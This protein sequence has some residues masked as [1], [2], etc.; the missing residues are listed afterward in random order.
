V[1]SH[2]KASTAGS[3]QRQA[4][5]L[6]RFSRGAD[7][8]FAGPLDAKGSS[9]PAARRLILPAGV[10]V[11]LLALM[12]VAL[13]ASAS[14]VHLF[15]ETFGSVA[16]PSFG[17]AQGIAVDQSTGDVLVMDAGGMP[18]IKRYNADGTPADFSALGTN[19]ID[20]QGTGDET[21]QN[22]LGFPS[23]NESQIAVDNSG[24]AT[25]GN[26]YVTQGSPNVINIFS[27]AGAYLGQLTAAGATDF[28]EA[29]GVAVDPSGAV[30]VGDYGSGIQKF[31]PAANPPVNADNTATFSSITNPCTL[32][33][34]AGPTAGFLFAAQYTGPISKIDS[35]TGELKYAVSA[36]S[37]TT[38]SV[39]SGSGHVFGATGSSVEEFDAVGAGGATSVGSAQLTSSVRG[40]A[41]DGGSGDIYAS[42]SG[43]AAVEVFDG[44]ATV[45][46]DVTTNAAT[47]TSGTEATLNGTVNPDGAA[48]TACEF[49]WGATTSYGEIAACVPNAAGIGSGTSPV[50]VHADIGGLDTGT[51]YHFR[52]KAAN[53][54]GSILGKDVSLQTAG[55]VIHD[56]WAE[57]V[58]RTEATLKAEINPEGLDT[59]YRF[60]WGPTTAYGSSSPES[61]AGLD[62]SI[63]E[64]GAF[65]DELAVDTTYHYRVVATNSAAVKLGPD[66]TF[67]T[68]PRV[69][70]DLN[71]PNQGTRFGP[72]A[73]LPDCRAYEMVSPVDKGGSNVVTAEGETLNVSALAG[74]T[75]TFPTFKAFGDAQSSP[76]VSQYLARR[77][78]NGWSTTSL[79]PPSGNARL[80]GGAGIIYDPLKAF[81]PDLTTGWIWNPWD[82][83][84]NGDAPGGVT[85]I[86]KR[87]LSSDTYET[88]TAGE[89][90]RG[91]W[92]P[93]LQGFSEDGSHAIFVVKDAITPEAPLIDQNENE[94]Y[95][96]VNGTVRLVSVLPNGQ[97]NL[98]ASSAGAHNGASNDDK[99]QSLQ[100][101]MSDDG[102]RIFWTSS[103]GSAVTGQIY[104]RLNGQ[105]TIPVSGSVTSGP[106]RFW[107]ASPDGSTALFSAD[108]TSEGD[109]ADLYEFDV[110]TETPTLVAGRVDGVVGASED[111]S[112]V[113]LV[114][115][116]DLDGGATAGMPNLYL[117]R[118]G[119][120]TFIATLSET[121]TYL[122]MDF[123]SNTS[124]FPFRHWSRVTGDGQYLAF[125]STESLTGYDNT[126]TESGAPDSE[127]Y[128]Y[129]AEANQVVCVSC[130]PSGARPIGGRELSAR[131]EFKS[132]YAAAQLPVWKSQLY[133]GRPLAE[134]G[135]RIFFTGYDALVPQDT[136]G[137]ADAYQWEAAGVGSCEDPGGCISLLSTGESPQDSGILDATPSGDDVFFATKSSLV[138]ADPGLIDVY[139][140]KVGGGFP[141]SASPT[142]CV[143]D[144][145]Q[146]IPAPPN[147]PTAASANF[148]GKGN[149]APLRSCGLQSKQA[150]KLSGAAESLAGKADHAS[151]A[152]QAEH[153]RRRS[154]KLAAKAKRLRKSVSRCRRSNRGADR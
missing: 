47:D 29:C 75:F 136:N 34:G 12:V 30:Y 125:T 69:V 144:A 5:R 110:D 95:E 138:P 50:P 93:E 1:R 141:Q 24:T 72:S 113:Y 7:A 78:A 98:T 100:H 129:D 41:I 107:M 59:A 151:S 57:D 56:T 25:D 64:V 42:R 54:V 101:A 35:S 109:D 84:L 117:S 38:V 140:V 48:I 14:K 149:P 71:C 52:L 133:A 79:N 49:E 99:S 85:N 134:N 148:K 18:S 65:L 81:S 122:G 126:D 153:L 143:G 9:A 43:S 120:F 67:T 80:T 111:L 61:S 90:T 115:K 142:P 147:D 20:G 8:S 66:H 40:I 62:S 86:Y 77:G 89:P 112:S 28:T 114:S 63:H 132:L 102:S 4:G 2:A 131:P 68:Y 74:D 53:G 32:A 6:G 31:V 92:V 16:Q 139:D 97:P 26:I 105:T 23:P 46:P 124:P 146:S 45:F 150:A 55:P 10:F 91:G 108:V 116:E 121:D 70:P 33:A 137:K 3:T 11:A 39:D 21:P 152:R 76:F 127:I 13:P 36:G 119:V 44:A 37:N 17:S 58:V 22:G 82:P 94:L 51:I 123:P 104:V 128:R 135:G 118:G 130:N 83:P 60:E 103:E 145:C 27:S 96:W 15:K 19:V 88:V 106:S 154:T 73:S 87:E